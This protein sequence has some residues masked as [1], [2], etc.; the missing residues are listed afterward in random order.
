L[1]ED[2]DQ[3][4]R[5]YYG[6]QFAHETAAP[7]EALVRAESNRPTD[8]V[9]HAGVAE[10]ESVTVLLINTSDHRV[11]EVRIDAPSGSAGA[12]VRSFASS[13]SRVPQVTG[14]ERVEADGSALRVT[15]G[16]ETAALVEL[17]SN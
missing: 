11:A 6:I 3:P 14:P 10:D 17:G 8:V 9:A 15:V 12:T 4:G 5:A 1:S 2:S 7:G 13:E 16:P